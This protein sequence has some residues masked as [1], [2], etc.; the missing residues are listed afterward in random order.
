IVP[1]D[2]HAS[3]LI[4]RIEDN[5]MPPVEEEEFPRL[6]LSSPEGEV[7]KQWVAGGA[8]PFPDPPPAKL[9]QPE[10]VPVPL[11]VDVKKIFREACHAC[12]RFDNAKKGISILNHDLLVAKRKVIVAG[13]PEQS[14]LY[15][16]LISTDE[17]KVMPPADEVPLTIDEVDT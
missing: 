4:H 12:H 6:T 13:A 15:Q 14:L 10:A 17:K 11:A 3:R 9:F 7:L 16:L 1:G 2:F 5:S 8:P